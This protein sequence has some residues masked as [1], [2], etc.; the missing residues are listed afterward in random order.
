MVKVAIDTSLLSGPSGFRGMGMY[1]RR[2][3]EALKGE[4]EIEIYEVK[5]GRIPPEVD[6]VHYPSFS[7][8]FLTLPLLLRKKYLVTI[9]DLI[10]LVFPQAYP[11][12]AKGRL[13]FEVQKRL[14]TTAPRLITDSKNSKSDI[15]RYLKFPEEKIDVVYLAAAN[16]VKRVADK[17]K[18][19]QLTRKFNLPKEFVLYIGDVNYN[20]NLPGLVKA[21]RLTEL[22][23]VIIGKQ[24]IQKDF[25][26]ENIENQPLIELNRLVEGREDVLRLG[27]VEEE[28]LA[29]FYT[30]ASVYCQPSLYE[31]FG[32]SILEAMSCGCPVVTSNVSSLPEVAGEAAVLVDPTRVEEIGQAIKEVLTDQGTRNRLVK[33]GYQQAKKFSWE[34]VAK[35]TLVSYR[36]A[37]E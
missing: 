1:T 32:L 2:L 36:K 16:K 35:E 19:N 7:P 8:Y 24:A 37:L 10:P 23:L 9:H 22:P 14:L 28:D 15:A 33:L 30:L 25:D 12:G 11:P 27:F 21:C 26:S 5:D 4:K 20:K 13:I 31:G 29:G 17:S 18:L 6:L 34:K 3:T